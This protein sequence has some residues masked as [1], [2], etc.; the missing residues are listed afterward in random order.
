[1]NIGKISGLAGAVAALCLGFI[2]AGVSAQTSY[3]TRP[4]TLV[5]PYGS[6]GS[7]D[8]YARV[9]GS[10][11]QKIL[12]QPFIVEDKPGA[13]AVIG[14]SYVARSAPDGYTLLVISNTLTAN[15]TILKHKP[16]SLMGDFVAVAPINETSLVLVLSQKTK[17]DSVKSL[18]A[19]AKQ[20]PGKLDYA[21]SGIGTPYHLAGELFKTM[22][23]I[24]A[25][26]IPYKS[27]GQAR[28]GVAG[29]EV[30][31]MFDA[32]STMKGLIASGKVRP[33]ATTGTERS[34]VLPDVPTVI[35][36]GVP[37]YTANLWL[38]V[39]AP[40]GTP[41]E[42]VNKLNA[43]INQVITTPEIKADWAKDGTTPM[44]M[45]PAQYTKYLEQ[46]I[47]KLGKI[48]KEAHMVVEN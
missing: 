32:I 9:L 26:H 31:F 45:T 35:E 8:V 46:D 36:A 23:G 3:P 33:I 5:V 24:T 2:S 6:G 44:V 47:V 48:A 7:A 19:L 28:T 13:G 37:G 16:Y 22:A 14:T 21:S 15:E 1:M 11:L 30:D 41:P 40:K 39:I 29:G 20:N 42:I 10:R 17:A 38:G 34:P 4:I 27:S 25:Q 43:A 12:G 18:I